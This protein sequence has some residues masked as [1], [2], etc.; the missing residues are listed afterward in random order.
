MS[1]FVPT[2]D[3]NINEETGTARFTVWTPAASL[4]KTDFIT[5]GFPVFEE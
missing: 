3:L 1:G 2:S 4:F 5:Q